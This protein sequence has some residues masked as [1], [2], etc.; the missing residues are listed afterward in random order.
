MFND[1]FRRQ[2]KDGNW[3]IKRI[4]EQTDGKQMSISSYRYSGD[5]T[6]LSYEEM[7]GYCNRAIKL[8]PNCKLTLILMQ[9]NDMEDYMKNEGSGF[10]RIYYSL[11]RI[12]YAVMW[13]TVVLYVRCSRI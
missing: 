5:R 4:E 11:Y 7:N 2:A 8:N 1:L 9:V 12:R 6:V 3:R 10:V 13:D